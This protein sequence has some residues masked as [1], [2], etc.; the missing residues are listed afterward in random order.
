MEKP[1]VS[2]VLPFTGQKVPI[3]FASWE[4]CEMNR[5]VCERWV[6]MRLDPDGTREMYHPMRTK[7]DA[8]SVSV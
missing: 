1:A 6:V 4:E 5:R 7:K 8:G 3:F 2:N